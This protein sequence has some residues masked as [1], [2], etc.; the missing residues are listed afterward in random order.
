[1]RH[2]YP[3]YYKAFLASKSKHSIKRL[4]RENKTLHKELIAIV[5]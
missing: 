5:W 4:T 1:M 2:G 3:A